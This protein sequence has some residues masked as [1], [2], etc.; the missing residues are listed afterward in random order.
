MK[1]STR[2]RYGVR[3]MI[4]LAMNYGK[5][6]VFLKDIAKDEAISEKYLSIIIIPLKS[7]GLVNSTRGA[8]GGYS[9]GK[10]PSKITMKDLVEILEGQICL[11]DCIK[12]PSACTRVQTCASRDIWNTLNETISKTLEAITLADL[13]QK[14]RDKTQ[15]SSSYQI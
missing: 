14:S 6:P 7:A 11:V 1:L 3:L 9:L 12:K 5:G 2:T 8:Y 13:A 15:N 10:E 4:E